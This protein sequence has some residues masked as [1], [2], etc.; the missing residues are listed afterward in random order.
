VPDLQSPLSQTLPQS[1]TNPPQA[2]QAIML[3]S[4]GSPP[5]AKF[6]SYDP[7][8]AGRAVV[9]ELWARPDD[10]REKRQ[11]LWEAYQRSG[12]NLHELGH[13]AQALERANQNWR[14]AR[15]P[16]AVIDAFQAL[17][18]RRGSVN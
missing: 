12:G 1:P 10:G 4:L 7:S 11:R 6:L 3:P 9:V 13:A 18:Q 16:A 15:N 8:I 5:D 2:S 14:Q 17:P